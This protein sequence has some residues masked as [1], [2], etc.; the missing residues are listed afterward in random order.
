MVLA[1]RVGPGCP[2]RGQ[3]VDRRLATPSPTLAGAPATWSRGGADRT[4]PCQGRARWHNL[5]LGPNQHQN[6]GVAGRGVGEEKQSQLPT[7]SPRVAHAA[8]PV[9]KADHRP[10]PCNHHPTT[11][12]QRVWGRGRRQARAGLHRKGEGSVK[13]DERRRVGDR[14][15]CWSVE[16]HRWREPLQVRVYTTHSTRTMH[17]RKN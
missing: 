17:V 6:L 13:P 16:H 9:P 8:P 7:T 12:R 3:E 5:G 4:E 10:F 1:W 2:T 15:P 11:Q 14:G